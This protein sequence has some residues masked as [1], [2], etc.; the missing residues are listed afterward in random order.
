MKFTMYTFGSVRC[1]SYD[2]LYFDH[3]DKYYVYMVNDSFNGKAEI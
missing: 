3:I 1:V 2:Y